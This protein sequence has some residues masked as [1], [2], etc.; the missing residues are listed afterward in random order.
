M[1]IATAAAQLEARGTKLRDN[2]LSRHT[3]TSAADTVLTLTSPTGNARLL[4]M[5]TAQYSASVTAN[6]TITHKSGA[7]AAFD[8]VLGTIVITAGTDGSFIPAIPIPMM[9]DDAIEAVADAGG[10]AITSGVSIYES[11]LS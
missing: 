4:E 8:A 1:V 6:V 10:A 7:G 2:T 3:D 5:V 11:S 9:P